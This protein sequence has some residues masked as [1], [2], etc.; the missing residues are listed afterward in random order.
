MDFLTKELINISGFSVALWHV[1]AAVATLVLLII[2]IVAICR[3]SRKKSNAQVSVAQQEPTVEPVVVVEDPVEP[4]PTDDPNV[5]VVDDTDVDDT[6]PTVVVVDEPAEHPTA[7]VVEPVEDVV[8]P[9]EEPTEQPAEPPAQPKK[10]AV[11]NYHISLRPDGKWQVK[12]SKGGKAI[13]LFNTQAEA[14]A[15]A[16]AR[17]KS[18]DG[19]ITIHKVD[20]RIRKQKY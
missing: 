9:T 12:L 16:K 1:L 10:P 20:G 17:A 4:D 2:V 8:E 7:E 14:I 6:D 11:K 18:Q 15:F 5:V 19:H 3:A 13:K